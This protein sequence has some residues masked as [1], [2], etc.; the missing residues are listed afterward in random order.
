L[1]EFKPRVNPRSVHPTVWIAVG[2]AYNVRR[3]NL[4][5]P[6]MW[7]TSMNDGIHEAD[8]LHYPANSPDKTY[9]RAADFRTIDL[10]IDQRAQ[11]YLQI[12][13][14]LAP[15]GFD[16]VLHPGKRGPEAKP[17]DSVAEHVHCEWQPHD[18]AT[19]AWFPEARLLAGG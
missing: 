9:C 11:F 6:G 3:F 17:G 4:G 5:L 1:I 8:S 19:A 14:L 10:T 2:I 12:R 7:V 16:V 15:L 13:A 18:A